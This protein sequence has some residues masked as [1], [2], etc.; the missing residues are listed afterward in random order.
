MD[1]D[2]TREHL[3]KHYIGKMKA[4]TVSTDIN[5]SGK[6]R[7]LDLSEM[8]KLLRGA[9]KIAQQ[10]CYCRKKLGNCSLPLDGCIELDEDAENSIKKG[11]KE[12]TVEQALAALTKSYDAGLVHMAYVFSGKEK[13]T[14]ICSCC[15]CCCHSL[16]AALR[17]GYS[18]HVFY[19]EKIANQNEDECTDCGECVGRCHFEAR[20]MADDKLVYDPDKCGGC[21]L[22]LKDCPTGAISMVDRN[23][24]R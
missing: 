22:C 12:L 15:R 24:D 13:P 21:G 3:E 4:I 6:Q 7:I 5:I 2:W 17:F 9:N 16:S 20:A 19:S 11:A 10:E 1:K 14:Y 8:E 18:D 23:G